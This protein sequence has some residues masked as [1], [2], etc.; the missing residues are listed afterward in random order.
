MT[1][2]KSKQVA[3]LISDIHY[4]IN[5]LEVANAALK[6]AVDKTWELDL[7][8]IICGDLHD[9]K[10]NIRGECLKAIMDTLSQ[11]RYQ[12]IIIRG[13]HDSIN[14]KSNET[15]LEFLRESCFIVSLG[16]RQYGF[17]FEPL[18]KLGWFIP[19]QHDPETFRQLINLVPKGTTVFMHQGVIGSLAGH[20]IQDKSAIPKEWLAGRRVISGHYHNRQDIEL[21]EGG[22]LTYLGNPYTL[23]FGEANDPEK[24]YH[25]LYD[26]GS[27]AFVPTNL[28]RH[29]IIELTIDAENQWH[30]DYDGITRIPEQDV[31]WAK[32][33]GPS[34]LLAKFNKADFSYTFS[35]QQDFR[36]DLIPTDTKSIGK[37]D[38]KAPQHDILDS[39]ITNLTNTDEDRKDRLKQLWRQLL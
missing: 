37:T 26:D 29:R 6:Q 21:P 23:G 35:I 4:N 10:A 24:G 18:H 17:E 3:V 31:L 20:Y 36:L 28:R 15:S 38:N 16:L 39:L 33:T 19:Y 13:N 1:R 5:T 32:V 9:T 7:P 2:T 14:E 22:L 34:D 8:L 27:L 12:P 25:I 30:Y 11:C